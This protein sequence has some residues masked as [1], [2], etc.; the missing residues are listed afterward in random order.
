[1][2]FVTTDVIPQSY[3]PLG[4]FTTFVA[5]VDNLIK[6]HSAMNGVIRHANKQLGEQ[7]SKLGGNG[8]IG[9]RYTFRYRIYPR[10][11]HCHPHPP[12]VPP[13]LTI[14]VSSQMSMSRSRRPASFH[15]SRILR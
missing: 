7:A 6:G 13:T 3:E 12:V 14:T 9:I 15:R 8:V 5:R 1:M 11:W 2:L 4:V 10:L